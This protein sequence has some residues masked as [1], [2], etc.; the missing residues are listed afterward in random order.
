M[1]HFDKIFW[2]GALL[3]TVSSFGILMIESLGIKIFLVW[4]AGIGI[5]ICATIDGVKICKL[6][7][8]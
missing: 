1:N 7:T 3:T 4:L 8:Q 6:N 2:V 5:G